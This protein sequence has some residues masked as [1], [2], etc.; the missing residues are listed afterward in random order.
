[1]N[2]LFKS[3]KN[4]EKK[5]VEKKNDKKPREIFNDVDEAMAYVKSTDFKRTES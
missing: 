5:E 1:M 4:T 3:I 2:K